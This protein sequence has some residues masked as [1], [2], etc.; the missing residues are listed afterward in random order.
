MVFNNIK[1]IHKKKQV[2]SRAF[3]LVTLSSYYSSIHLKDDRNVIEI[4]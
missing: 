4:S 2:E 3:F 1:K